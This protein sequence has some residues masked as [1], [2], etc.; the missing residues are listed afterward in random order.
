MVVGERRRAWIPAG[1]AYG[2]A[3]VDPRMPAGDLIYDVELLDVKKVRR[4]ETPSDLAG[5]PKDS[6]L[7]RSGV[8][9]RVMQV[10]T[11]KAHPARGSVVKLRYVVWTK[12]GAV[13]DSS[14]WDGASPVVR[15]VVALMEGLSETV[16][17]MVAGEKARSWIPASLAGSTRNAQ[18]T[19]QDLVVDVE[20]DSIV[21]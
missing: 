4:I 6:I 16:M 12:N 19:K 2:A 5:P 11:G 20:L 15:P 1:L 3:S 21:D 8:S 14:S 7:L 9:Y 17:H 10:G 18:N 13:F